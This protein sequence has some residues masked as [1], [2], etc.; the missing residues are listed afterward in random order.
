MELLVVTGMSGAGKSTALDALEDLGFYC[1]DNVPVPLLP[2]LVALS[3]AHDSQRR[4]AVGVDAREP[5]YLRDFAD[6]QLRL[7]EAGHSVEV[8]FLEA[9]TDVLVRRYSETRRKHPM[10]H[11]PQAIDEERELLRGL[12]TRTT[13]TID[14]ATL[15]ARELRRMIRD[16]YGTRGVLHLVL[17]SFG[18][19]SGLPTFADLVFDV[20]FLANPYY[21]PELRP[22]TGLDPQVSDYVLG[23]PEAGELLDHLERYLRFMVPGSVREGRSYLTA[24][25]GCTGGQ[26]R[27]V[28]LTERLAARLSV[29]EPLSRPPPQ[30]IVRHR[31]ILEG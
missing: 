25:I 13:A 21:L 6:V 11:L 18:F 20:R 10:G 5:A 19:K 9:P 31:D 15:K 27:S 12:R 17:M 2:D 16:R 8:L 28:A 24:A 26:H 30:L 14:T 29:G 22:L 1:V 7:E 4:V 3:A 23:Q